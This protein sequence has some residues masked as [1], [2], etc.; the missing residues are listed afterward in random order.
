MIGAELRLGVASSLN[1]WSWGSRAVIHSVVIAQLGDQQAV[2][3]HLVDHPM[4]F[5]DPSLPETGKGMPERL[6]FAGPF[7]WGPAGFLDQGMDALEQLLIGGL[8][9]EV[10]LPSLFREDQLHSART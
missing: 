9:M 2:A 4:F 7:E 3:S 8:P 1:A 5:V 10:V 6:R